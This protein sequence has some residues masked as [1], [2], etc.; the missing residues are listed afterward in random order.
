MGK[1]DEI[2]SGRIAKE[3]HSDNESTG[4]TLCAGSR[5]KLLGLNGAAHLNDK[6]GVCDSFD[7]S[8]GRWV[9]RLDDTGELKSLKPDNLVVI[10]QETSDEVDAADSDGD[11]GNSGRMASDP[12]SGFFCC[13]SAADVRQ[14]SSDG[15]KRLE[16]TGIS[17][18][19][20]LSSCLD[21]IEELLMGPL[22]AE[23]PLRGLSFVDSKLEA[24]DMSRLAAAL[25]SESGQKLTAFGISKNPGLPADCWKE[26]FKCL[27]SKPL[28]LDFGDNWLTD[29]ALSPLVEMLDGQEGLDKLYLDG[30]RLRDIS[31]LCRILPDTGVTNLDLGDN[32]I[33]DIGPL[34]PALPKSVILILV[35]GANP[36]TAQGACDIFKAL[37]RTSLDVLYLNETGVDDTSLLVLATS[38]KDA[39]LSELHIDNTKISDAGVREF[40]SCIE[41]SQV[42]YVDIS[43]NGITDETTQLLS[44]ALAQ[45]RREGDEDIIPEGDEEEQAGSTSQD[46]ERVRQGKGSA[47]GSGGCKSGEGSGKSSKGSGIGSGRG[48]E[49]GYAS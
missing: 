45:E 18:R 10:P 13:R 31:A 46:T 4:P 22:S 27:P 47:M 20:E 9:V 30:N 21:F 28:W 8:S 38:L 7:A 6:L 44:D 48:V 36:I 19:S 16:L 12:E 33:E 42:S 23:R 24:C 32:S 5:V 37:P 25:K 34:I 29:E 11:D 40:I 49:G 2:K 14:S 15:E 3:T 35:L 39:K 26:L 17:S 41:T 43:G 1:G